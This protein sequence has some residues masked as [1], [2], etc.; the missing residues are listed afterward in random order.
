MPPKKQG[1]LKRQRTETEEKESQATSSKRSKSEVLSQQRGNPQPTNKVLPVHISFPPRAQN[2][3]RIATWNICG[4]AASQKKARLLLRIIRQTGWS[5][6]IIGFQALYR[7]WRRGY[8]GSY[9][10][11][12]MPCCLPPSKCCELLTLFFRTDQWATRRSRLRRKIPSFVLEHFRNKVLL[13]VLKIL[14]ALCF[15]IQ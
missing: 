12:S 3:L 8:S 10:N 2:T 5:P 15:D 9:R 11:K 6:L 14:Y 7:S 13:Y 4:L 1:S